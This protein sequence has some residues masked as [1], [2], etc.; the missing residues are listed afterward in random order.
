MG[1]ALENFNAMGMWRDTERDQPIAPSGKLL[2]GES[3]ESIKDLKHIL[4]K[5]H[6]RD[7]YQC[8]TEKLLTYAIGRGLDY[9]DVETVDEIVG[10]LENENGRFSALLLGVIESAPFQK[11]RPRGML[12]DEKPARP[13]QQR[14]EIKVKP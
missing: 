8:L 4:A 9:Y 14:A 11:C 10:R 7:F 3:F 2:T 1:L 5:N 13:L 6:L 12:S